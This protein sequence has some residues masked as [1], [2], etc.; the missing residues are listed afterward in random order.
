MSKC[1]SQKVVIQIDKLMTEE[2]KQLVIDN[3]NL[4]HYVLKRY[5]NQIED[6]YE[7]YEQE[8]AIALCLAAMRFDKDKGFSFSTFAISYIDG[9]IKKHRM[10]NMFPIKFSRQAFYSGEPEKVSFLSLNQQIPDIDGYQEFGEII[11]SNQLIEDDTIFMID[12]WQALKK[13]FK[14]KDFEFIK[15]FLEG[16]KQKEI[17]KMKNCSVSYVSKKISKAKKI[18]Q[19][20]LKQ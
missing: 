15:L 11:S 19:D 20:C 7:E 10:Q 9:F 4:I 2:Q 6:N 5:K 12:F 16:Y 13:K 3:Y 8:A 17:A 18:I 1:F 14:E